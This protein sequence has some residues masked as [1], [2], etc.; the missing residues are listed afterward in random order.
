MYRGYNSIWPLVGSHLIGGGFN[1]FLQKKW[2]AVGENAMFNWVVKLA[3]FPTVD[4][5]TMLLVCCVCC[6]P[7]GN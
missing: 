6:D 4:H 3:W 5:E 1:A 7:P 2:D